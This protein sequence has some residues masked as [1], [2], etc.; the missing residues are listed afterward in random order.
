[1]S[2]NAVATW[3]ASLPS[4]WVEGC[5]ALLFASAYAA[6]QSPGRFYHTW[7]HVVA[8]AQALRDFPCHCC[9]EAFLALVFHDA[10][11][12]PGRPDNEACSAELA[13]ELLLRHST[14]D[15]AGILDVRAMILATRDRRLPPRSHPGD[16]GTVI[17][18]DLSILAAPWDRY[19]AY[20]EAVRRE[21]CPAVIREEQFARGRIAFLGRLLAAPAIFQTAE[22]GQR[23]EA[24]ARANIGRELAALR[25]GAGGS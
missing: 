25:S 24:A 2:T 7:E 14:L 20:A 3:T 18:I 16:A 6:Y 4:E 5:S 19:A 22:G 10:I 11:Y 17:D 8:C 12:V 1:M 21:F 15:D 9:R 23:W 13:S